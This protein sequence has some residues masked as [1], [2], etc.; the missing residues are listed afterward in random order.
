MFICT[1]SNGLPISGTATLNISNLWWRT[2]SINKV[3]IKMINI[4]LLTNNLF[5][6]YVRLLIAFH[7]LHRRVT[8]KG[9][10]QNIFLYLVKSL[11]GECFF[12]ENQFFTFKSFCLI[13]YH[14][15]RI[16]FLCMLDAPKP[17]VADRSRPYHARAGSGP[18]RV[19]VEDLG[20][21]RFPADCLHQHIYSASSRGRAQ[22]LDAI[23][24]SCSP[25]CH[26]RTIG[27]RDSRI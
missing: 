25:S 4:S 1:K 8:Q 23:T 12:I 3:F 27:D 11:F 26:R 19:V 22:V 15:F 7:C 18:R 10:Y 14:L 6:F 5:K 17:T 9:A 16:E 20:W 24:P 21:S 2:N 13:R